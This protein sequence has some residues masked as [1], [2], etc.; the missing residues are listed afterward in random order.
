MNHVSVQNTQKVSSN[1]ELKVN[2]RVMALKVLID[3]SGRY[4]T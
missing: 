3:N 4:A 2:K 1:M